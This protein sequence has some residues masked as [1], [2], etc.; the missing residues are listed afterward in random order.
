MKIGVVV[1]INLAV[2][3][4]SEKYSIPLARLAEE[5]TCF[6]SLLGF[7]LIRVFTCDGT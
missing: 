1:K 3:L 7:V 2:S 6:I 5:Y 4:K